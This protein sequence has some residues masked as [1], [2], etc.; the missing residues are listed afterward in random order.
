MIVMASVE[1]SSKIRRRAKSL[2]MK[3]NPSAPTSLKKRISKIVSLSKANEVEK[4]IMRD[5]FG[6]FPV[7]GG[8]L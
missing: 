5:G 2:K 4:I 8:G 7:F 6:Y 3:A 1:S